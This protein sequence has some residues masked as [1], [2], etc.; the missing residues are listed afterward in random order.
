MALFFVLW[1]NRGSLSKTGLRGV[2]LFVEFVVVGFRWELRL[3][4]KERIGIISG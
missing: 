2:D 3:L 1:L 4:C